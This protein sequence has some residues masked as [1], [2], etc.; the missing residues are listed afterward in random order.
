MGPLQQIPHHQTVGGIILNHQNFQGIFC[1]FLIAQGSARSQT[2]LNRG[3]ARQFQGHPEGGSITLN[4]VNA[5]LAAHR[6]DDPFGDAQTKAG[7]LRLL[8]VA[9]INPHKIIEDPRHVLFCDADASVGD[10]KLDH[11]RVTPPP[12]VANGRDYH[13]ALIGEFHRIADQ[14][15]QNLAQPRAI[16]MEPPQWA[17]FIQRD[18]IAARL[19]RDLHRAKDIGQHLVHIKGLRVQPHAVGFQLGNVQHV[20]HVIQQDLARVAQQFKVALLLFRWG[21]T[22][23]E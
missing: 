3:R 1:L 5:D 12:G 6:F 15:G 10:L 16:A 22:T 19:C 7:T 11:R 18:V 2:G 14:V 17:G 21:V 4:A 20:I 8:A 23:A 9:P 13:R